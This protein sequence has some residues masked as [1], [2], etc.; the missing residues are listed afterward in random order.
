MS[1]GNV[2]LH[3]PF[4]YRL[5]LRYAD[6]AVLLISTVDIEADPLQRVLLDTIITAD[7]EAGTVHPMVDTAALQ[8]SASHHL[9]GRLPVLIPSE[10][11]VPLSHNIMYLISWFHSRLWAWFTAVDADRSGAIS[12][13]ELRRS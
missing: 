4:R 5:V 7:T 13:T 2:R 1:Y 3:D 12:L 10:S 11:S 6:L 9:L 8:G